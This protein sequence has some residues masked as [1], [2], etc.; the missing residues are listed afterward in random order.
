MSNNM[1]IRM[2]LMY[3]LEFLMKLDGSTCSFAPSVAYTWG[4]PFDMKSTSL[5]QVLLHFKAEFL[6]FC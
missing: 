5:V 2:L 4:P 3:V 1:H 6:V